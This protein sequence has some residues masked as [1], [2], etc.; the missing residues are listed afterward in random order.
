MDN[1]DLLSPDDRSIVA[2][3]IAE[4]ADDLNNSHWIIASDTQGYGTLIEA[5]FVPVQIHTRMD[6]FKVQKPASRM[7]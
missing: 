1:W 3:W 2:T 5:G 6:R 4:L 7:V